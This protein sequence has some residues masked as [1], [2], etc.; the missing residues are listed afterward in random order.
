MQTSSIHSNE[1]LGHQPR[2]KR[3]KVSKA[4]FTCRVKKIKCDGVQPC[5]QCKARRRPCSFSKDGTI[6]ET[7]QSPDS[8]PA[9]YSATPTDQNNNS[10]NKRRRSLTEPPNLTAESQ[11]LQKSETRLKNQDDLR[12]T[13]QQLD[14]LSMMWP[15]EGKEGR[16]LV[17]IN[18]LFNG[19]EENTPRQA[20]LNSSSIHINSHLLNLF[21]RHRYTNFPILP[22]SIFYRLLEN[23]DPMVNQLLLYSMYCNAAHHSHEDACNA[24]NYF[25]KAQLLLDSYIDTPSLSTVISLCLLSTYESNRYGVGPH[26]GKNRSR[27]YSDIAFRMCYDLKLHK[28]YSFHITGATPDDNELRKR[29]YWAC[30]C[31]DKVQSLVTGRPWL[32]ASKDIDIDFPMVLHSDDP[33]EYEINTCFVEHIKLMQITERVLLLE[34]PDRQA[35]M[36]RSRENE[37]TVLD[38]DGQLL[39]WLKNLPH[40]FQWT[41]VDTESDL[42]PTHPPPNAL[43]AHLHLVYNYARISVLQPH[44]S[45]SLSTSSAS[46]RIQQ[47]CA[48][49]ATNLTQLTCAMADQ[50][51]FIVSFTLVAEA[52]MS[53]VRVHIMQC[54]DEKLSTARH[55]R[56]M[57]QRSLRSLRSILHHRVIDR[58]Q[59]FT[60]TIERALADADTG[61]S[62]S[63]NSSPKIHVLSPVIPRNT[64]SSIHSQD[65]PAIM[66][67][68][69][70]ARFN[71]S[72]SGIYP[73]GLISPVSSTASAPVDKS[74]I[75]RDEELIRPH[76]SFTHAIYNSSSSTTDPYS[77]TSASFS[78]PTSSMANSSSSWKSP[79][80][81][82]QQLSPIKPFD[83]PEDPQQQME[84]YSNL[85]SKSATTTNPIFPSSSSSSTTVVDTSYLS[86][87]PRSNKESTPYQAAPV[88]TGMNADAEL[89]SLW[90]QQAEKNSER[91]EQVQPAPIMFTPQQTARYGLGVYASAQQ[92]H[93]DVIRQHMPGLKS[94]NRPVLLNHHGQVVVVP[95]NNSIN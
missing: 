18:L 16:W 33:N 58:I 95:N 52:I 9:P 5:M 53:S 56:F 7:Q 8:Y 29:V 6:D 94:N 45:T 79:V 86:S 63:R 15:G 75:S 84:M 4:C 71:N 42:V 82:S 19:A 44:A 88:S 87:R 80:L 47:R 32:L 34:I 51:N 48:L 36:M 26:A 46:L 10:N 54:A 74:N 73:Y 37:E 68:K 12:K 62:S 93:T 50:P 3:L 21:F 28:R 76:A 40:Q 78:I 64:S 31:L 70:S 30:Y 67:E 66:D 2:E 77:R 35:G 20:N 90:D 83:R 81:S 72:T 14:K 43:V 41:P 27:I 55:A 57:F 89:Y 1:S 13:S 91:H 92:H 17:D 23:C 22:K 38:L 85:W 24:D 69:W 60:T 61:N 59:E 49:V 39:Y 11:S 65:P 25:R